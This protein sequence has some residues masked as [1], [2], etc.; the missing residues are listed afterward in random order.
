M[1]RFQ[2]TPGPGFWPAATTS[3]LKR[4]VTYWEKDQD[5][6]LYYVAGPRL[7]ALNADTGRPLPAFGDNGWVDLAKGFD[8]EVSY[9]SYNSAPVIC[10]NRIILGSSYYASGEPK[11]RGSAGRKSPPG[12][13][14]AYDLM[15]GKR[16][17]IFHTIPHPGEFG[18]DTWPPEAWQNATGA[19]SWGGMTA[20]YARG[21]VFAGTAAAYY[22][23]PRYGMNLFANTVLALDCETGISRLLYKD[24]SEHLS[25]SIRNFQAQ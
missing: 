1:S 14:V 20:D 6:R 9:A 22:E 4:G 19:N 23:P 25:V 8:R 2:P 12:D 16:A 7:Y 21:L 3:F 11:L 15:T 5:R 24:A 13:I 10:R 17:W 18:Y